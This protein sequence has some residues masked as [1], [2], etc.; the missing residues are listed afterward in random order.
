MKT[1]VT[2]LPKNKK[3]RKSTIPV[4]N[5]E[6]CSQSAGVLQTIQP[7]EQDL[8]LANP[9]RTSIELNNQNNQ[10]NIGN[11]PPLKH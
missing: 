2:D 7:N 3:P 4:N 9:K 11:E 6:G 8:P 1:K 5:G 10:E